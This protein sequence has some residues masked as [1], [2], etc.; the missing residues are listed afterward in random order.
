MS[1]PHWITYTIYVG[2]GGSTENSLTANTKQLDEKAPEITGL[3][4]KGEVKITYS[5]KIK[6]FEYEN[7]I[8][9]IEVNM[10]EDTARKEK[11]DQSDSTTAVKQTETEAVSAETE[12]SGDEE[13]KIYTDNSVNTKDSD[14]YSKDIV[15]YLVVPEGQEVPAGLDKDVVIIQQPADKTYVTSKE[16]LQILADLDKTEDIKAVG[17]E[18]KDVQDDAVKA[19]INKDDGE[20]GKI[21]Q[22]GSYDKWDLKT[23][24]KQETNFAI[25]SSEILPKEEKTAD[26]DMKS[27]EKLASQAVQMNMAMFVDRSADEKN[28]LAK[29]EWYKVYGII[30]DAQDQAE[31][32]YKKVTDSASEKEKKEAVEALISEKSVKK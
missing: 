24:I 11:D 28:D 23:M 19:A 31:D 12:D 26:E 17:L 25:E 14:V 18:E 1:A 16:A 4:V 8:Y 21:Y 22:A 10:V 15:K 30:F 6:I 27:F 7:N 2:E 9:L 5:D 13:E 3:T 32:L 29:A 20:D